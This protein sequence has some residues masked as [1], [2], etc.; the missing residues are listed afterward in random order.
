MS[1]VLNHI[2]G[3]AQTQ[4]QGTA[5]AKFGTISSW[6]SNTY[7]ARISWQPDATGDDGNPV[8]SGWAHG[9]TLAVGLLNV[10]VPHSIGQQVF[11]VPNAGDGDAMVIAGFIYDNI[12]RPPVVPNAISGG[13]V[14]AVPGELIIS[15]TAGFVMRVCDD[16]SMFIQSNTAVNVQAPTVNLKG[17]LAVDGNITS[18]GDVSDHHDSLANVRNHSNT[19]IHSGVQSGAS[20][21]GAPTTTD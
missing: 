1:R 20:T 11:C 14:A 6:D 7:M 10:Q 17:N 13:P 18:T 8:E 15:T 12:S 4:G 2:L 16:G 21:T 5:L 19:H 9:L 3:R